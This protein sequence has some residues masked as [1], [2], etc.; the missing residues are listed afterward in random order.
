MK[1]LWKH[2]KEIIHFSGRRHTKTGIFSMVIGIVDILGFVAISI[3]SGAARGNG[4]LLLGV[5][6]LLLFALSVFG[7]VMSYR[8]FKKKDI[9]YRF[10]IIGGVINGFMVILLLILYIVGVCL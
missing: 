5:V 4:G 6:G 9:F 2:N 8:S 10:P 7:F 3:A 1:M